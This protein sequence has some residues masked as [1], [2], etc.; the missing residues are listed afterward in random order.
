MRFLAVVVLSGILGACAGTPVNERVAGHLNPEYTYRLNQ[1]LFASVGEPMTASSP[2]MRAEVLSIEGE[3]VG[4]TAHR[5]SPVTVRAPSGTYTRVAQDEGGYFYQTSSGRVTMNGEG[6]YG[7]LYRS[8]RAGPWKLFWRDFPLSDN[9]PLIVYMAPLESPLEPSSVS[10]NIV[11]PPGFYDGLVSTL[12]YVGMSSGEIRFVYR[13][14][15]DGLARAAFTQQ[16]EFDY[17]PGNT[18]AY[19]NA[20]FV[21]HD[22]DS[23]GVKYTL[24]SPL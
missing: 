21:V 13:E 23:V 7:G 10:E 16:V 14:Y 24:L 5:G 18:F 20:R 4:K 11:V 15:K 2:L 12:S 19:Q 1:E 22:A 6:Y 3:M 17:E 8:R 9:L